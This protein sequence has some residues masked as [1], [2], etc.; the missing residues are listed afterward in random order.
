MSAQQYL[1]D[2]YDA[3][4]LAKIYVDHASNEK[5]EILARIWETAGFRA[6]FDPKG[7]WERKSLLKERS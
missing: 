3:D 4:K 6:V 1:E 2:K 7:G 5:G